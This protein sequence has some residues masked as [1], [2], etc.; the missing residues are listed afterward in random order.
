MADKAITENL[1]SDEV[2]K[3]EHEIEP[4]AGSSFIGESAHE[5]LE[6]ICII[7]DEFSGLTERDLKRMCNT[8][9]QQPPRKHVDSEVVE[10]KQIEGG[11]RREM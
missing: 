10:P 7:V 5:Y 3:K 1:E 2:M 4:L 6:R 11:K 8:I 9:S